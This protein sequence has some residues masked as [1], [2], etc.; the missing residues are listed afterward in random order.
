MADERL[1]ACTLQR[2]QV[3]GGAEARAELRDF[4]L[5]VELRHGPSFVA[6]PSFCRGACAAG[7]VEGRLSRVFVFVGP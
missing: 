5:L 3:P 4:K 6:S 7:T 1:T 2:L